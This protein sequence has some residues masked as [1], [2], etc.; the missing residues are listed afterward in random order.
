MDGDGAAET[1]Q[2][3][4]RRSGVTEISVVME[5]T[6]QG[7]KARLQRMCCALA[8]EIVCLLFKRETGW[9]GTE[10]DGIEWSSVDKRD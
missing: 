6:P 8:A 4:G 10:W 9:S 2:R 5:R 7:Q 3:N 1:V